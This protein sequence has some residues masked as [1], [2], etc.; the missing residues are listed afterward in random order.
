MP[1]DPFLSIVIPA[2]NE[3]L[4]IPATLRTIATYL[5]ESAKTQEIL[6]VDDGSTDET[7]KVVQSLQ[8]EIPS[9]RLLSYAP[10]RGKGYAVRFGILEARGKYILMSDA[11]LS[12]PIEE[13]DR[14]LPYLQ[15]G[16]AIVIGTRKLLGAQILRHQPLWRETMGK[17]FTHI[18]NLIL[19]LH[20]SDF[21]C[22]FKAFE[23]SAAKQIFSRQRIERWTFDSEIL[24]L[25]DRQHY[26]VVEVPV[27]WMNSP[28]TK[29]HVLKDT[30]ISFFSLWKIRFDSL[31][32]KYE[33]ESRKDAKF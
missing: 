18:S 27:R 26:K 4:R 7:Q 11:D 12:T 14:F 5:Q 6:V 10:N 13:F 3:A 2:F 15:D 31:R 21:T 24:F 22:G 9:L 33:N 1:E 30:L 32:G 16:A 17:A 28:E 20:R 19:G 25:A 8:S 29:V 23:Q